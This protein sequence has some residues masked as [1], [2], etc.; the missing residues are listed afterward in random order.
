M[1][2]KIF[3][4]NNL[5]DES[6]RFLNKAMEIYAVL[7]D[8][9]LKK[10]LSTLYFHN[11]NYEFTELD[12]KVLSIFIAS[13]LV[14]GNL[15][16]IF[17]QY[18]DI[19]LNDLFDFV[20]ITEGDIKALENDN[21]EDFFNENIKSDLISITHDQYSEKKINF[22]TPEV[23]LKSL[24]FVSLNGSKIL[25]YFAYMYNLSGCL[26][27]FYNH[28]IFSALDFHTLMDGSISKVTSKENYLNFRYPWIADPKPIT[29]SESNEGP[30]FDDHIW[31]LLDD[32]QKKFIGQERVAEELFYNI[33]NNQ[34]LA[35]EKNLP[36]GQRSIIFLD[37]P[38][39]TGKTAIVK[40]ITE[41]LEIPFVATPATNYSSTGYVGGNLTDI[42]KLLYK[43][44]DGDL[45][46]A[47][48]GIVVI[49]EFDKIAYSKEGGL[50][51]KKAIQQDL[52][53]FL[54]GGKY[55]ISV[56]DNFFSMKQIE[57]D[58]SNLTFIC[59]GALTDL[60]AKKEQPKQAIGFSQTTPTA[61][62]QEY[63]ITPDDLKSIGL[64]KE[65]VA[66][67]NVYLHTDDYSK[68]TLE[69]ILRESTISPLIGFQK[70]VE[71][72]KKELIIDKEVYSLIAEQAY[73]LNT[74]AR[75]LQTVMNNI[76]TSFLRTVLRG[77]DKTIHLDAKT[78]KDVNEQT[79]TRKGRG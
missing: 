14:D 48:R 27:G 59:L 35:E 77:S 4:Y 21:Y 57:F 65:L 8:K 71:L 13:L 44:A 33:I 22:I 69:R 42:L 16:Q 50:G 37:G 46:L 43:R 39:G 75:S 34:R 49:D 11:V 20:G 56:G 58:T 9:N 7:K 67:F 51:M 25:D 23:I 6:K 29:T 79:F 24:Q 40:D 64:E 2:F 66:R 1:D 54:G 17:S 74:G 68:K 61:E 63:S 32:I 19:K 31:C 36:D 18:D 15:K 73:Q 53:D 45:E 52:L 30:S 10:V 72:Y 78:I 76:R 62:E 70:W 5:N 41:K 28:S 38:S 3:E 55:T 12:K 60:R 26:G 47:Q